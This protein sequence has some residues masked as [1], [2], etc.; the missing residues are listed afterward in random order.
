MR[1]IPIIFFILF[2]IN[3]CLFAEKYTANFLDLGGGARGLGMGSA[4]T[5]GTGEVAGLWWNPAGLNSLPKNQLNLMHASLYQNLYKLDTGAYGH[6]FKSA[7]LALEVVRLATENIPFT[8][9]SMFYD[10]GPDQLPGTGDEGEDNGIRDPGEPIIPIFDYKGEA[11]WVVYFSYA[12]ELFPK[13]TVGTNLKMIR[14]NIG[15]YHNTGIGGDLGVLFNYKPSIRFG[16]CIKDFTGTHLKWST[17]TWENRK[18][19][20]RLGTAYTREIT[21]WGTINLNGDMETRFENI[22]S[23]SLISLGAISIDPYLGGE[24]WLMNTFA[25]RLGLE[26]KH[27]TAGAGLKIAFFQVDYAFLSHEIDQSH[28][29]S[30]TINFDPPRKRW[31]PIDYQEDISIT[32]INNSIKKE[33]AWDDIYYEPAPEEVPELLN[34][35]IGEVQFASGRSELSATGSAVLDSVA[36]IL[37]DF[38]GYRLKIEG[39]TDVIPINTEQF[40]SNLELS[41]IRAQTV[42]D[43]LT[44]KWGIDPERLI[45]L[46]H[47][48]DQPAMPND[49]P[50]N[51]ALN[52]RVEIYLIE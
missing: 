17:G 47:G 45:I 33:I 5:A 50:E 12:R 2:L 4:L 16:M 20:L 26:R 48:F 10:F 18:P 34:H 14:Q 52:R 23:G 39:H 30:V 11:N 43:Y 15:E 24:F 22:R 6:K 51:M 49:S 21:S 19:S 36:R 28:R 3:S 8:R 41:L 46:G 37:L 35:K 27:F 32:I 44:D 42:A 31:E 1:K 38:P 9:D 13:F 25:L 29:L 40:P 7:A